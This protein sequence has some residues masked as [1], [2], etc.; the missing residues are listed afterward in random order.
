M[1]IWL[2]ASEIAGLA[3][4]GYPTTKRGVLD[5][6]EREGWTKR[7][8]LVRL[9][10]KRGGAVQFHRDLLTLEAQACLS[11]K[12]VAQAAGSVALSAR[13]AREPEAASLTPAAEENRDARLF[14]LASI[15]SF[16][17][18]RRLSATTA[19]NA[20]ITSYNLGKIEVDAWIKSA[21]PELSFRTVARW[22]AMAKA[23]TMHRLAVDHGA[24]RRGKGVLDRPE[25]RTRML[26]LMVAQPD[27]PTG[28]LLDNL[29]DHFPDLKMPAERTVRLA[30]ASL[31]ESEKVMLSKLTNPDAFNNKYRLSGTNSH[32]VQNLNELWMIDAS[33]VDVLT[34]DGR[35]SVYAAIDVFS[36]RV[37]LHITPTPRA[38][39]VGE[40]LRR[41]IL[42]WGAPRRLKTDNGSDF[43]AKASK[44]LFTALGIEVDQCTPFS[45]W[46]KGHVERVIR[47]FQHDFGPLMPGFCGH[48]VAER[49]VIEA[50][51]S[52]AQRLGDTDMNAFSVELTAVELQGYADR[53]ATEVYAHSVHS[54]LK[55]TPFAR[56]TG[57]VGERKTVDVRTLDVLLQPIAGRDGIRT[58]QKTGIRVDGS[59]YHCASVLPDTKVLVRMDRHD[60]GKALLFTPEGDEFLGEAECYVL[61]G[62]DPKEA[63]KAQRAEQNR[64]IAERSAEVRAE[65]KKIKPRDMID[66]VLRQAAKKNGVLVE[67]P[68]AGVAHSTPA[69][70]AAA[71]A[72]ASRAAEPAPVVAITATTRPAPADDFA[73]APNVQRLR[74]VETPQQRFRR[75]MAVEEA[76]AAGTAVE[77]AELIW[78]GGYQLGS[79]YR[80]LKD[81]V[82]DF[83]AD[84]ALR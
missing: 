30:R 34:L 46:E 47:T 60:M 4:P 28:K 16:R 25:V 26:A 80:T 15:E 50:R 84:E 69:L 11:A 5:R 66:A 33:P 13:A 7:E 65:V 6:A 24:K 72:A 21:L 59:H 8:E 57:W 68:R 39:A 44:R 70:E 56:A 73:D 10:G 79:E 35:Q 49:K 45:G 63:V 38:E 9:A 74:P 2:T 67:F 19:D 31:K 32:D 52:F 22:R 41:G 42:A 51:R 76:V 81:L 64:I 20:F 61:T 48:N 3:L 54:T 55:I 53:W 1:R 71:E 23:G 58:M 36:R 62:V 29:R 82:E 75:A 12:I 18:G 77:A 43:V 78:L 83:G 40:L 14:V 17:Q 27:L 37:M